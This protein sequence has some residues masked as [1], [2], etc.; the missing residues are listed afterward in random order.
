MSLQTVHV[1]IGYSSTVELFYKVYSCSTWYVPGTHHYWSALIVMGKKAHTC[2]SECSASLGELF[3]SLW[4]SDTEE[5][6]E[7]EEGS[8]T[9]SPQ[10]RD[11]PRSLLAR[12]RQ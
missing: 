7:E 2:D 8:T 9:R 1:D 4:Y 3:S 11:N 5:E 10:S 12:R 6:E